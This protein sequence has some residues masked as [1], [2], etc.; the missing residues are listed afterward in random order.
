MSQ[1][2]S[3]M[4]RHA[5]LLC[6]LV[7]GCETYSLS[8]PRFVISRSSSASAV[9][10]K[11]PA[12]KPTDM[13][14]ASYFKDDGGGL[15]MGFQMGTMAVTKAAATPKS[16]PAPASSSSAPATKTEAIAAAKPAA[17]AA[18]SSA[19][20][21]LSPKPPAFATPAVTVSD[22]AFRHEAG[23]IAMG[24]MMG[25][26]IQA[27]PPAAPAPAAVTAERFPGS[28][29]A[30]GTANATSAN[31]TSGTG[32]AAVAAEKP[33]AGGTVMPTRRGKKSWLDASDEFRHGTGT[34][35]KVYYGQIKVPSAA[36]EYYD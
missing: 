3:S 36:N 15:A 6:L 10:M 22:E 23:G 4:T 35:G 25:T 34:L 24:Y 20:L 5:V 17:A 28:T 2:F 29:E 13:S 26:M 18:P 1:T 7:V 33:S 12:F 14:G 31:A 21:R 19:G 30:A 11:A 32:A 9:T 8:L 27:Q 16:E